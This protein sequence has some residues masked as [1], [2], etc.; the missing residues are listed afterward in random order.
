MIRQLARD[1]HKEVDVEIVGAD[2]ELDRTVIDEIGDPLVHLI[3]NAM[4]HG[5][6]TPEERE[7]LGKPRK[8][9]IKSEAYHRGNHVF[10]EITDDDDGIHRERVMNKA[11][12]KGGMTEEDI[13][14]MTDTKIYEVVM[15]SGFS[16]NEEIS[17]VSG[18][19]VGLN[20]VKNTIES[21]R[22]SNTIEA[23][24]N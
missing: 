6:E 20:V 16:T 11:L 8:G 22:G 5:I 2:T 23:K 13:E 3:R 21:V 10:V 17:D 12:H 1:L 15:A 18:R 7:T 9:K 14:I 24:P 19:G 4:D